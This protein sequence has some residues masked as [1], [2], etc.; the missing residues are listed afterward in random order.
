MDEDDRAVR[1]KKSERRDSECSTVQES[2]PV[3]AR[4]E[5]RHTSGKL[6][7]LKQIQEEMGLSGEEGKTMTAP[8]PQISDSTK[9]PLVVVFQERKYTKRKQVPTTYD[10]NDVEKVNPE[11]VFKK[12][13]FDVQK[14][15]IKGLD[16]PK[17]EEARIAF[18]MQLGAKA[19]K[20]KYVNY[21]ELIEERKQAKIQAREQKILN[22]KMGLKPA[23]ASKLKKVKKKGAKTSKKGGKEFHEGVKYVSRKLIDQVKKSSGRRK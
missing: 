20:N 15:G 2:P 1:P 22:A 3:S 10:G 13:K 8:V 4:G 21:R 23:K 17:Q 14:F 6:R 9:G 5:I 18:A 16:R 12:A 7:A 19:P 11:V